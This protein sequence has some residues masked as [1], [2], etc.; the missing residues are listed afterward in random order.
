MLHEQADRWA[1]VRVLMQAVQ[2]CQ[3]HFGARQAAEGASA[4]SETGVFL[5]CV[6]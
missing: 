4:A 6:A 3:Q 5:L 1:K 2:L